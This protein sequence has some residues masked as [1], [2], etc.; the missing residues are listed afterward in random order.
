MRIEELPEP[1][2]EFGEGLRGID[3]RKAL[4]ESGPFG[5][6][7]GH[8]V[9]IQLGLV[10]PK[11]ELDAVRR[12]I[13][14]MR[15][16]M[17]ENET[18][19]ARFHEFPG[20]GRAFRCSLTI[21]ERFVRVLDEN[22]FIPALTDKA[23]V[24]FA[25]CLD[26]YQG[27][28]RSLFA[29]QRPAAILVVFP[30]ELA[31]LRITNPRL[32]FSQQRMLEKWQDDQDS[33]QFELFE[34]TRE[35]KVAA[36]ELLPQADELLFRSFHRALKA[37]C[38]V[39]LNCV[40][41]QVIRR[42][43]YL[44]QEAKQSAATRAWNLAVALFYKA[45]Q[46]P[47]RP[48]HLE[49]GVCFVGVSFHHLKRRAGDIVY[50]SVAQAF[51]T[52]VEPFALKGT[53]IDKNQFRHKQP[54]LTAEQSGA[55]MTD[56]LNAY[57]DRTG[58]YPTRVVVHKTSRYEP[59]EREGFLSAALTKSPSCHLVGLSPTGFRL[60]RRGMTEPARG[61]LCT[62]G[63]SEHYL[64]TTGFVPWW[65]EYPGPHIPAPLQITCDSQD[66]LRDRAR[67]VLA[68]TKMNWNSADG[69]GRYPITLS[70]ARRVGITMTEF[71]DDAKPN[72]LYRFY[73]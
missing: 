63:D 30:E 33:R 6:S 35:E 69:I 40:P 66:D 39:E 17:M 12:W 16:F 10:C 1:E 36:A 24:R 45:G 50:A 51:S 61:T 11:S 7:A 32:T 44:N 26:L 34:P 47:W 55:L 73:M 54:F 28:I 72:P 5:S 70:F 41:L 37:A 20:L 65:K 29:D 64:F 25:T 43:T 49:P 52:D 59:E 15:G 57:H 8:S 68:L 18:N 4:S 3:P 67:E 62:V 31:T 53:A 19:A 42:H 2:L 60:L 27:A 48:A 56:T 22:R 38:M 14:S 23:H 46:V 58:S 9:S 21:P 13:D 71:E